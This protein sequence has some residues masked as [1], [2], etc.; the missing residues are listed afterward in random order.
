MPRPIGDF[1]LPWLVDGSAVGLVQEI[2][3]LDGSESTLN[4]RDIGP[5]AC[6]N[7]RR[8]GISSVGDLV[9]YSRKY[10]HPTMLP[11]AACF[12]VDVLILKALGFL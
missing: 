11:A 5:M 6:E 2:L 9:E 12:C 7:L 10:G 4:I 3:S 1:D 8:I